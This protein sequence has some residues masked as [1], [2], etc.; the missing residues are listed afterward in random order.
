MCSEGRASVSSTAY[1]GN[2]SYGKSLNIKSPN[3][4]PLRRNNSVDVRD[5]GFGT[6][7]RNRAPPKYVVL[8]HKYLFSSSENDVQR[9]DSHE[10]NSQ[11]FVSVGSDAT[12]EARQS[13]LRTCRLG[14]W[15]HCE[16]MGPKQ[17]RQHRPLPKRQLHPR[18][19]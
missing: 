14:G 18:H 1:A 11:S 7:M 13:S 3:L 6:H 16:E 5:A 2:A 4:K 10:L 8:Q 19:C 17:H 15:I 12:D 9:K